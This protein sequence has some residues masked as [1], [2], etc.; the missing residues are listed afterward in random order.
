VSK[1]LC[2]L[3]SQYSENGCHYL[4]NGFDF[5]KF[6]CMQ[7]IKSR[8]SA[9]VALLWHVRKSK[10][11]PTAFAVLN[12]VKEVIPSLTVNMFGTFPPP[13]SLPEWYNFTYQPSPEKLVEIYNSSAIYF[14]ASAYE[15]Y[16]LTV[17][18]AM[19]CG[20]AVCCTHCKGFLE[21]VI[22]ERN[23]LTAPCG[24]IDGLAEC[25][26]R[27]IKDDELRICLAEQAQKDIAEFNWN[28]SFNKF[29]DILIEN[30]HA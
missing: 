22:P 15:G 12:K 20:C 28:N 8:N 16:G 26:I 21:M 9:S 18:E 24:D 30:L 14:S 7:E 23:G 5:T 29:H 2:D 13:V 19:I 17:G 1:W 11:L 27:L 25:L 6:N 3:V 10:D 4:P